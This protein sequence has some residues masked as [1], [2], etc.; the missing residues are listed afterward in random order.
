MKIPLSLAAIA[1]LPALVL[2][3]CGGDERP[4]ESRGDRA[5]IAEKANLSN[6]LKVV[7]ARGKTR[8]ADRR[9]AVSRRL[10]R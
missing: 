1:L 2:P 9:S 4:I 10:G 6:P 8:L 3:G 5:S 7:G